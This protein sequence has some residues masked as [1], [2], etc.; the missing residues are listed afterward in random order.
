VGQVRRD[1]DRRSVQ[2]V[3]KQIL[4]AWNLTSIYHGAGSRIR[5][6]DE[7]CFQRVDQLIRPLHGSEPRAN[8]LDNKLSHYVSALRS[9]YIGRLH[10]RNSAD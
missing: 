6:D 3:S 7:S 9:A 8:K 2:E 4:A 5:T 10:R 1:W